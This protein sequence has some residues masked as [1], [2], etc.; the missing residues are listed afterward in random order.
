MRKNWKSFV[1]PKCFNQINNCTCKFIPDYLIGIDEEMQYAI[2]ILNQKRYVTQY[3][4]CGHTNVK[5]EDG[6]YFLSMYIQ[7][8]NNIDIVSVPDGWNKDRN[9]AIYSKIYYPKTKKLFY[10]IQKQEL[11]KLNKWV[12]GLAF[13][14]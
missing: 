13:Y 1:C 8:A 4:C 7:F 14:S 12:D 5:T 3:C 6:K 9:N 11:E 2:K 10:E